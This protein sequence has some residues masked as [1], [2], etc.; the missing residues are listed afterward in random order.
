[1]VAAKNARHGET[2]KSASRTKVR[3][4][5]TTVRVISDVMQILQDA[6]GKKAKLHLAAITGASPSACEKWFHG[7]REPLSGHL[8]A[9]LRTPHGRA[10]LDAIVAGSDEAWVRDYNRQREIIELKKQTRETQRRLSAL[11]DEDYE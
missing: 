2:R 7:K 6:L 5:E 10:V 8:I 9:I 4:D 11:E 3:K 1:M